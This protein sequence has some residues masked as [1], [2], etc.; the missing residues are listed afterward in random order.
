[1]SHD[2]LFNFIINIVKKANFYLDKKDI[3][4]LKSEY[5][6]LLQCLN[7]FKRVKSYFSIEVL[8][9]SLYYFNNLYNKIT[10]IYI[11]DILVNFLICTMI[12]SKFVEDECL[13]N[14]ILCN[15]FDLNL[16]L[17]NKMEFKIINILDFNLFIEN[18]NINSFIQ[19]IQR[20]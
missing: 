8:K 15:I 19:E 5:S 12:S 6:N 13:E 1:M 7:K 10:K 20:K 17:I 4:N 2:L 11:D 9:Y 14:N 18:T 3:K 16:K